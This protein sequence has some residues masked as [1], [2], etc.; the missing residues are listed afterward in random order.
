MAPSGLQGVSR[1]RT[2]C[3]TTKRNKGARLSPDLVQREFAATGINQLWVAD[4]TYIPTSAGF[5]YLAV[6]IDVYSR[7]LMACAFGQH[8]TADLVMAA[9]NIALHTRKPGL[10]GPGVTHNSTHRAAS[11]PASPL[12]YALKR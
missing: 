2:W 8:K 6:G 11:T 3:I 12:A 1:S 9:L 10:I 7:Q 5:L 4:M